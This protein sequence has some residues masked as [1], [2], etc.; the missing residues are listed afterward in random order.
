MGVG[1]IVPRVSSSRLIAASP[2]TLWDLMSSIELRPQWDLSVSQFDRSGPGH[3]LANIRLRYRAPLIAGLFWEW[4]GAYVTYRP[5]RRTAV[6]MLNGS[7]LR[8]FKRLA[9]SWI[10]KAERG[11]THLELVVLFESRL[12]FVARLMSPFIRRVLER[13]LVRL[14]KLAYSPGG[15]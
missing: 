8:P 15:A 4:E 14:E 11:G 12:P 6:Q 13:S 10:L 9:G 3:D 2:E 5:P 7:R 1:I